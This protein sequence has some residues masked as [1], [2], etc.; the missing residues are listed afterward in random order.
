MEPSESTGRPA[1]GRSRPTTWQR[2]GPLAAVLV[3]FAVTV[4]F[5]VGTDPIKKPG[6]SSG[7]VVAAAGPESLADIENYPD[8]VI[9]LA[10]ATAEGTQDDYEWGERC[11]QKSGYLALPMN[12]PPDCFAVFDGD[13]GGA[14]STGVTAD[15]IKVVQYLNKPDDPLLDFI[16]GQIGLENNPAHSVDTLQGLNEIFGTYFE[17]YGRKV[18]VTPY[19]ATGSIGD[20]IAAAADAETIARDIRPFAVLG[21]PQ[22]TNAFG[23]TLAANKVLCIDCAQNVA[24]SWYEERRPYVWNIQKSL[25]QNFQMVAE[26]ITKRL[27][28][29]PAEYAGDPEMRDKPRK[30]AFVHAVTAE[31]NEASN[32]AF[33]EGLAAGGVDLAVELTFSN[34]LTLNVDGR[35]MITKLKELGVTSVILATDPVAPQALTRVATDQDYFPEWIMTGQTLVEATVFARTYDQT[36]WAHAF[37]PSNR[38]PYV[39]GG[40]GSPIYLYKWFFGETA[41]AKAGTLLLAPPL[42]MLYSAIQGMGPIVT[43][44]AFETV[45]FTAPII[46]GSSIAPQISFGNRGLFPA[47]D[48]S[49][50]DDQSEIWWDSDTVGPTEGGDTGKGVWQFSNSAKRYLPGEWPDSPAEAFDAE[51]SVFAPET[52]PEDALVPGDYAPIAGPRQGQKL[53]LDGSLDGSD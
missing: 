3:A 31:G 5:V 46:P 26:Y 13:N 51:T 17:T 47:P 43:P 9:P 16:Y 19:T 7:P 1:P 12:P 50:L 28:G 24:N 53:P 42:Q 32:D 39:V 48:Y 49:I 30:F 33:R 36:Q 18:E 45:L 14:T 15:T 37:G 21:G 27:A 11:D 10:K 38:F 40:I 6:S 23:D 41:P 25:D 2:F 20:P 44:E 34:P 52:V 4:G 8:G 35:D 22:L 29:E